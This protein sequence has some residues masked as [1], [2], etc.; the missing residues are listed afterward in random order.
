MDELA[1]STVRL[2]EE[3]NDK[4]CIICHDVSD[5]LLKFADCLCTPTLKARNARVAKG[6]CIRVHE[7]CL[8][9]WYETTQACIVCRHPLSKRPETYASDDEMEDDAFGISPPDWIEDAMD[10][11]N[12]SPSTLTEDIHSS[13]TPSIIRFDERNM[14]RFGIYHA[15]V[16]DAAEIVTDQQDP[17]VVTVVDPRT[18][19]EQPISSGSDRTTSS[20]CDGSRTSY[21]CMPFCPT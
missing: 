19:T 8:T 11:E 4:E 13:L 6:P 1:E 14:N 16:V 15:Q 20:M 18:E 7:H 9:R 2:Q 3:V 5:K 12:P 10:E 17:R 21:C